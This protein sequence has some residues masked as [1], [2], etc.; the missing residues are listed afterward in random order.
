MALNEDF[1]VLLREYAP[2]SL[3]ENEIKKNNWFIN[4]V[5]KDP[6]W[7]YGPYQ[8]PVEKQEYSRFEFGALPASNDIPGADYAKPEVTSPAEL[9]GSMKFNQKDL[10]RHDG[11][12]KKSFLQVTPGKIRQFVKRMQERA[13]ITLLGDGSICSVTADATNLGVVTVDRVWLLTGDEKVTI[14][15]TVNDTTSVTGYV[16]RGSI[17][18]NAGTFTL[19]TAAG[20]STGV[21]CSGIDVANSP[22]LYIVGATTKRFTS[23]IDIVFPASLGGAD[24]LYGGAITKAD[25]PVYQ[26][27][28]KDL[29]SNTTYENLKDALFDFYYTAEQMGRS[30]NSEV[31]VPYSVFKALALSTEDQRR[32]TGDDTKTTMGAKSMRLQGPDGD[33]VVTGIRDMQNGHIVVMDWDAVVFASRGEL[34]KNAKMNGEY[35][36]E[37][38]T[39]GYTYIVDRKMEGEL[40]VTAPYKLA[41]AK[42]ATS[43]TLA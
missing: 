33:M 8:I 35:F 29:S 9:L 2:N 32:R 23:L 40:I 39:T 22:K 30:D 37:R 19:V 5:K 41:G 13:S 7:G 12:L 10:E 15:E 36:E 25:S 42:V 1:S 3:L 14:K 20:G 6:K 26:P 31:L 34:I 16:K 17:D 38:A 24:T 43:F 11:D 27:F 18:I 21:D 28:A 4:K